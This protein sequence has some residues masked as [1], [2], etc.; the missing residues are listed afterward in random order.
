MDFIL[1]AH[2]WIL[3]KNVFEV[4]IEKEVSGSNRVYSACL[5]CKSEYTIHLSV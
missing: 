2:V 1:L 5:F 4:W 3:I